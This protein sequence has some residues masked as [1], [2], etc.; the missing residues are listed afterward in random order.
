LPGE[1]F[2]AHATR[3]EI[4]HGVDEVTQIA[5]ELVELPHDQRIARAQHFER[6]HQPWAGVE[7]TRGVILIEVLS[8]TARSH[9]RV[10]LQIG[11]LRAIRPSR[12]A[13]S[14]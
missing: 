3:G 12:R 11:R 14:Q 1:H 6:C 2:E 7:P 5:S 10:A 9:E 4:M 13:C 8:S